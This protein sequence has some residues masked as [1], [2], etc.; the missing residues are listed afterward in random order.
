MERKF[1][2]TYGSCHRKTRDSERLQLVDERV[3]LLVLVRLL[4]LLLLLALALAALLLARAARALA[5]DR[6]LACAHRQ[7]GEGNAHTPT[8]RP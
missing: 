5:G 4:L 1:I 7:E 3:Q 6:E 8:K 2:Y